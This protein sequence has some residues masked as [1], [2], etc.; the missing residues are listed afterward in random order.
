MTA[1]LLLISL[2]GLT[3]TA[4]VAAAAD[5]ALP[6]DALYPIKTSTEGI[7]LALSADPVDQ[8]QL[9]LNF[10]QARV[11]EAQ[12]LS[13]QKQ[14]EHMQTAITGYQLQVAEATKTLGRLAVRDPQRAAPTAVQAI[15]VFSGAQ[16]VLIQLSVEVPVAQRQMVTS[17]L[18]DSTAS[19]DTLKAQIA[20]PAGTSATA[21]Q[22]LEAT[23]AA[24]PA[25]TSVGT[26]PQGETPTP[27]TVKETHTPPGQVNTPPG[28]A[29]TP[30]GQVNTPPGQANTPPG[31][32]RTPPGPANTPPGQDKN[33][34]GQDKNPPGQDK[35]P[36]GQDKNLP[37][38]GK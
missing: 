2:C 14:Y 7:R 28:Q 3:G 33:P 27:A 24:T 16:A 13:S 17:A 35:E 32:V 21:T 1:A 23:K 38:K 30:P 22:T 36:P 20:Y 18:S 25:V 19:V 8:V 26:A 31:Q 6:G 12:K 11:S 29:N 10:A 34:P 4:Q 15:D 5:G 9:R 37:D